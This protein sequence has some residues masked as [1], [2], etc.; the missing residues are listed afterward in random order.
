MIMFQY[1]CTFVDFYMVVKSLLNKYFLKQKVENFVKADINY[2]EE[3]DYMR[4][5]YAGNK[6]WAIFYNRFISIVKRE[7]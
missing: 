7:N 5:I 2:Q 6:K 4:L 1:L 3:Y